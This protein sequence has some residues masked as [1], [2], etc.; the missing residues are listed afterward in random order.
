MPAELPLIEFP[1]PDAWE[2]WLR[3]NHDDSPGSG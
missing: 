2:A 1:D 3:D